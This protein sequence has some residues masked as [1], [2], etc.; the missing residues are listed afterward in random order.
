M[1]AYMA[2]SNSFLAR[3]VRKMAAGRPNSPELRAI[4]EYFTGFD[5]SK[6]LE[7]YEFTVLDTEL[8]GLDPRTGDI[9]EIGAVKIKDMRLMAA[10]TFHTLVRPKGGMP[11]KTTLIHRITP[12]EVRHA[13]RLM[14]IMP[15]FVEFVGTSLIVGHHVGLDMSFLNRACKRILGGSMPNP[16]L[17]TMRL[18]RSYHEQS[19]TNH[20]DRFNLSISYGLQDLSRKYGLPKFREH[21]ALEDAIQTA[22]LFLFL[23]R[24]MKNGQVRTLKQ[25]H[26]AARQRHW[27]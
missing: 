10:Q 6:P 8:T 14:E 2:A 22:Y 12:E 23:V 7:S 25:L 16:C 24:K 19:Y 15:G 21:S 13:P 1:H 20:L 5:Q 11:V 17:D 9:L 4:H 3:L 26:Q 18:A 27:I